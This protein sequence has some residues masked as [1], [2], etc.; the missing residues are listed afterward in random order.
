MNTLKLFVISMR[1]MPGTTETYYSTNGDIFP[2]VESVRIT[3]L[4]C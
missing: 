2:L 4:M 1:Q 3:H